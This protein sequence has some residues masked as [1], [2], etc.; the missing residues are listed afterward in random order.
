MLFRSD[1]S[2]RVGTKLTDTLLILDIAL[3]LGSSSL[4]LK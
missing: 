1:N 2:I 4:V 3:L